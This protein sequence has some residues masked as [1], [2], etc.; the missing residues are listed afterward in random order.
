MNSLKVP[1]DKRRA[2][3][4]IPFAVLAV[5]LVAVAFGATSSVSGG[6]GAFNFEEYWPVPSDYVPGT[7]PPTAYLQIN[8]TGFGVGEYTY[9]IFA[10]SNGSTILLSNSTAV[11]SSEASFRAF[12]YVKVPS[13]VMTLEAEVFA[14]A[15]GP[16]N[17]VF[18][19]T[20]TI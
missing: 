7:V 8:Y 12:V 16:R 13:S 3:R 1:F 6:H 17:L 9:V 18:A 15:P 2:R 11:V 14:L 19:K 5:V 4:L 10:R 20:L